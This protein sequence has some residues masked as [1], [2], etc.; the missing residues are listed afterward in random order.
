MTMTK[1][2]YTNRPIL[3][4]ASIS[5]THECEEG[6]EKDLGIAQST[7][8]VAEREKQRNTSGRMFSG[9]FS[10]LLAGYYY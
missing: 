6:V 1:L 2:Q 4:R 10:I 7:C 9:T 3:D 5:D 8:M